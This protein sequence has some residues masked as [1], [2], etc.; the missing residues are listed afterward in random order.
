MKIS[1]RI[2][3]WGSRSWKQKGNIMLPYRSTKLSLPDHFQSKVI[4]ELNGAPM[5]SP[6]VETSRLG[7]N[8]LLVKL[9]IYQVQI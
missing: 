9:G 8:L 2:G 3:N 7:L 6:P 5:S 1:Q 4:V